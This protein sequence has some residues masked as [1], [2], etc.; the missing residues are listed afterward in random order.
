[1]TSSELVTVVGEQ[2]HD[3]R[4]A[5]TPQPLSEQRRFSLSQILPEL[6]LWLADLGRG[7]QH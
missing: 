7:A 4:A 2:L 3:P 5:L 6:A 1:V